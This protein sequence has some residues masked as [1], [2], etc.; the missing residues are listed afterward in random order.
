M[1]I[2]TVQELLAA[3]TPSSFH[4]DCCVYHGQQRAIGELML[5][6]VD[7]EASAGGRHECIGYATFVSALESPEF[8]NWFERLGE[9]LKTSNRAASICR[10]GNPL[11]HRPA[12]VRSCRADGINSRASFTMS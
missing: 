8:G 12:G 6:R 2:E 1:R 9:R 11:A 4:D 3:T 7:G 5:M 10:P